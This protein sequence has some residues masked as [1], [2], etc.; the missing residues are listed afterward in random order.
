[1]TCHRRVAHGSRDTEL[2]KTRSKRVGL[3]PVHRDQAA[4]TWSAARRNSASAAS[5]GKAGRRVA[6]TAAWQR[7]H[8]CAH[9]RFGRA[10]SSTGA[11][12]AR[13]RAKGHIQ[14]H[15]FIQ[16]TQYN[17]AAGLRNPKREAECAPARNLTGFSVREMAVRGDFAGLVRVCSIG[18]VPDGRSQFDRGPSTPQESL[19]FHPSAAGGSPLSFCW[20]CSHGGRAHVHTGQRPPVALPGPGGKVG[21]GGRRCDSKLVHLRRGDLTD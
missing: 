6:L 18:G 10:S 7:E 11:L 4:E 17:W 1:M 19:A 14:V 16:R 21:D 12:V 15:L 9:G 2:I 8:D 5:L 20:D 13:T 3:D